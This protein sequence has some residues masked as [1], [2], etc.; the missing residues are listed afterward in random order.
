MSAFKV[1]REGGYIIADRRDFLVS[2]APYFFP[3]YSIL[4]ILVFGALDCFTRRC[5]TTRSICFLP[6]A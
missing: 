1:G 3:L 5:G 2:L 6:S 4:A